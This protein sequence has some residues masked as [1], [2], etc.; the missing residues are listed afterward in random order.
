MYKYYIY[1]KIN[2]FIAG[3]TVDWTTCQVGLFF[4]GERKWISFIC[5][6]FRACFT[7]YKYNI[8]WKSYVLYR[9]IYYRS[10]LH[11]YEL[12]FIVWRHF[13]LDLKV[14]RIIYLTVELKNQMK[15]FWQYKL[16]LYS[17]S[18]LVYRRENYW[19]RSG[20]I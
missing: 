8:K 1:T 17:E 3:K 4:F 15:F 18:I 7:K 10:H 11:Y 2:E 14:F 5:V 6:T 20:F 16:L 9:H 12:Y 19:I 13:Q